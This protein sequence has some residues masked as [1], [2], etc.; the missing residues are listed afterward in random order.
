[1]ALPRGVVGLSAVCDCGIT[2][3]YSLT[4]LATLSFSSSLTILWS[5]T[6][7]SPMDGIGMLLVIGVSCLSSFVQVGLY[8]RFRMSALSFGSSCS[9]PFSLRGGDDAA[10]I[11][12]KWLNK[13]KVAFASVEVSDLGFRF[14][15]C[16]WCTSS[17]MAYLL[18]KSVLCLFI[19]ANVISCSS[20]MLTLLKVFSAL[21]W[22]LCLLGYPWLLWFISS[23]HFGR[24][25]LF[26]QW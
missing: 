12:L 7:I 13:V 24:D 17:R 14:L 16:L 4:I 25:K 9:R 8:W 21:F 18:L 11:S 19:M 1:M 2:W 23:E 22:C 6:L 10:I 15:W 20:F 5:S 26:H 3:S